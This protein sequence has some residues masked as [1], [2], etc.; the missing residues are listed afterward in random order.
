MNHIKQLL[1]QNISTTRLKLWQLLLLLTLVWIA[2]MVLPEAL[3]QHYT[4]YIIAALLAMYIVLSRT[5]RNVLRLTSYDAILIERFFILLSFLVPTV[6]G[7][8]YGFRHGF[9]PF[10]TISLVI[11][12]FLSALLIVG[13]LIHV[14]KSNN[15]Y[16][17]VSKSDLF[18]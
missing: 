14:K 1:S 18:S 5:I 3:W 4:P 7:I 13:I 2:P 12:G 6:Y 15:Y 9:E 10:V 8:F 11:S 17:G 16:H